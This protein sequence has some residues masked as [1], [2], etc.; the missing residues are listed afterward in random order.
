MESQSFPWKYLSFRNQAGQHQWIHPTCRC[1][2]DQTWVTLKCHPANRIDPDPW[3][4]HSLSASMGHTSLSPARSL[5]P[6]R[7]SKFAD[8]LR[9]IIPLVP[10][11]FPPLYPHNLCYPFALCVCS[12]GDSF[13]THSLFPPSHLPNDLFSVSFL[14]LFLYADSANVCPPAGSE[15][16]S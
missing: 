16:S 5:F 14:S 4:S 9:R 15:S 1:L 11:S 12:P 6:S 3:T 8:S 13:L 2:V 7:L 10:V